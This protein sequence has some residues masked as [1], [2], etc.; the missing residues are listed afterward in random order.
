MEVAWI[1]AWRCSGDG[2]PEKVQGVTILPVDDRGQWGRIAKRCTAKL[3]KSP[4]PEGGGVQTD[5]RGGP[6]GT[7][8]DVTQSVSRDIEPRP[9]PSPFSRR[10][11]SETIGRRS[12]PVRSA[13]RRDAPRE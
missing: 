7:G 5:R 6:S 9:N 8:R 10:V 12:G 3:C 11:N 4:P 2:P 1:Q 13:R